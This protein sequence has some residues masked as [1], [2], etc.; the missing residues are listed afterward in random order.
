MAYRVTWSSKAIEDVDAIAAYIARDS[1]SYAAAVVRKILDTT[2]QLQQDPLAGSSIAESADSNLRE[3]LAYTYRIIYR[4]QAE[5]VIV[6][7]IVHSK[8][9][10]GMSQVL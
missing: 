2:R 8:R 4:I 1:S 7:A 10:L 5:T 6:A 9:L 3:E